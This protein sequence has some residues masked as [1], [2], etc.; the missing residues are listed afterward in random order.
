M[1]FGRISQDEI[2][3]MDF[4]LPPLKS[5]SEVPVKGIL[6]IGAP[7]WS[8]DGF[9][10]TIYP[11]TCRKHDYLKAYAGQFDAVEVNSTFYALPP[12]EK[13]KGWVQTVHSVNPQFKFCPK[14]PKFISHEGQLDRHF[15]KLPYLFDTLNTF[16]HHLGTTFLQLSEHFAPSGIGQLFS[17]IEAWPSKFKLALELRHSSWFKNENIRSKLLEHL[18]QHKVSLVITDTPGH[19]EVL[20]QNITTDHVI[21]RFVSN[22]FHPKDEARLKNWGNALLQYPQHGVREIYF[23]VH[24]ERPS[25]F[26]KP[27]IQISELTQNAFDHRIPSE[28]PEVDSAQLNLFS[29]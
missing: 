4:I 11:L 5:F 1:D 14:I 26:L 20:H 21:I 25:A 16:G 19:Q 29:F 10:G 9:R 15:D 7:V 12:L 3:K 24:E 2:D 23:F 6:R 27:L 17:F 28:H 18:I 22:T 13:V 8:E